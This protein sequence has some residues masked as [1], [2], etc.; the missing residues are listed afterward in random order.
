M[1]I[2]HLAITVPKS[3]I[4]SNCMF[5]LIKQEKRMGNSV[6]GCQNLT[7]Y[8]ILDKHAQDACIHSIQGQA[9]QTYGFF[10]GTWTNT[11]SGLM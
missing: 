10:C 7:R 6:I 5:S 11:S 9:M 1:V 3:G 4:H 2:R 8:G